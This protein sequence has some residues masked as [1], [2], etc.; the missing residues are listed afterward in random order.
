MKGVVI[1]RRRKRDPRYDTDPDSVFIACKQGYTTNPLYRRCE[2]CKRTYC[3]IQGELKLD[4]ILRED[5][6][7]SLGVPYDPENPPPEGQLQKY[8]G[9]IS[10]CPDGYDLFTQCLYK[11]IP[12]DPNGHLFCQQHC[13]ILSSHKV[14]CTIAANEMLYRDV[15]RRCREMLANQTPGWEKIFIDPETGYYSDLENR[16]PKPPVNQWKEIFIGMA[17]VAGILFLCWLLS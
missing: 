11:E 12:R 3:S 16:R 7:N 15:D 8:F 1:V 9:W 14:Y 17:V 4:K 13:P 6:G 5:T 2:L 10:D